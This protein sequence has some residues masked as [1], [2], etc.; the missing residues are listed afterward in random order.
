MRIEPKLRNK[1]KIGGKKPMGK[2]IFGRIKKPVAILLAVFFVVSLTAAAVSACSSNGKVMTTGASGQSSYAEQGNV[3][4]C[5]QGSGAC[6]S[7]VV[8]SGQ[9]TCKQKGTCAKQGKVEA[10]GQSSYSEQSKVTA[11][12]KESRTASEYVKGSAK[13]DC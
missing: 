11:S 9:G 5:N 8:T 1:D 7:N 6:D 13:S 4:A 10:S 12:E 3:M 2:Q